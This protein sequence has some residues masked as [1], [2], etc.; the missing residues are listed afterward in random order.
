MNNQI[1]GAE[2]PDRNSYSATILIA[3]TLS[4]T[5]VLVFHAFQTA[6]D[7]NTA[8]KLSI[9]IVAILYLLTLIIHAPDK[10]GIITTVSICLISFTLTFYFVDSSASFTNYILFFVC[11]VRGLYYYR[12]LINNIF[13]ALTIIA[14]YAFAIWAFSTSNQYLL[15]FWCFYIVQGLLIFIPPGKGSNRLFLP[16]NNNSISSPVDRQDFSFRQAR[17]NAQSALCRLKKTGHNTT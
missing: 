17:I 16:G 8:L 2:A 14:G 3:L 13:N 4:I 7:S 15:A 9:G 6:L 12:S 11:L 10:A 1:S 5:S